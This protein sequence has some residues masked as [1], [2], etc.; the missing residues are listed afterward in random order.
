MNKFIIHF[1]P[2]HWWFDKE[3]PIIKNWCRW[4][5]YIGP[6][7]IVRTGYLLDKK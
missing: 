2:L 7:T 1:H 6:F 5:Y 4:V 3:T